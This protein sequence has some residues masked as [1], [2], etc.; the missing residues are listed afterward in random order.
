MI[1][2]VGTLCLLLGLVGFTL[3]RAW[4]NDDGCTIEQYQ[5]DL[6]TLGLAAV[7]TVLPVGALLVALAGAIALVIRIRR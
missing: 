1:A 2:A 6:G 7:I 5:C 4:Y 3:A